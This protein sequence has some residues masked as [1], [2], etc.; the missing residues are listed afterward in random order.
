MWFPTL[1][2]ALGFLL[3]F[4]ELLIL[5]GFGAAGVP[6]IVLVGTDSALSGGKS[7]FTRH[8]S[9]AASPWFSPSR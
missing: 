8:S 2:I 1:L 6:G 4:I 3:I 5:P 9:T 7:G